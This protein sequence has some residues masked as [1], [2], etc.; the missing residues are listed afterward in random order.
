M[1]VEIA[2]HGAVIKRDHDLFIVIG[3][4]GK[5]EIPAEKVD[6]I[7]VSSNALISTQAI[8]L[9]VEKQIQLVLSEY[10]GKPF[11]RLWV[12][13]PGKNTMI[14]RKQYLNTETE[15]G[16]LISRD[17]V[18]IKISR[19]KSLLL[20]LK[21]NRSSEISEIEYAISIIAVALEKIMQIQ[22]EPG[23]KSNLLG[24]E[25]YCASVYFKAIAKCI[26]Q[27]WIFENRSKHPAIDEF[28]ALLNY[29]Y[30]LG[31]L[32]ME[33]IIILSGLDPNAGFFH[34]DSYGKPTLSYDLLE[35]VRPLLD[36][37]VVTLFT[38]RIVMD[39]WFEIQQTDEKIVVG[40]YLTKYAR[41]KTI[42]SFSE[43]YKKL[44]DKEGWNYCRK[45]IKLLSSSS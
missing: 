32:S 8:K 30:G 35:L 7:I 36:R 44:I 16:F 39:N 37:L 19:Q 26:P 42:D 18:K 20:Y 1:I 28:N 23:F 17:L 40:V 4:D 27:K 21:N 38:K 15:L 31:Y 9:C 3:D 13:N 34:S 11:A 25:G 12:A 5:K 6:C 2:S 33:K 10:S 29:V 22:Y 24:Q 45:L 41:K 43:K 14:R